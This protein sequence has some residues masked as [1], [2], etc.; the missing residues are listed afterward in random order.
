MPKLSKRKCEYLDLMI[1]A[2]RDKI[3]ARFYPIVAKVG[4]LQIQGFKGEAVVNILRSFDN[5]GS[6]VLR[7]SRLFGLAC[8]VVARRAESEAEKEAQR[9]TTWHQ[10]D[11]IL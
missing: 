11:P 8:P 2:R 7:L 10:M 4:G 9:V 5:D 1:K 3:V 6:G